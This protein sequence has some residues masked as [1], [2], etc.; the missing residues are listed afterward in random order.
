MTWWALSQP[1]AFWLFHENGVKTSFVDLD[2]AGQYGSWS[3][4][5]T[6]C[7]IAERG[8]GVPW[9]SL[10]LCLDVAQTPESMFYC[11]TYP[12][13]TRVKPSLLLLFVNIMAPSK[14]PRQHRRMVKM[15]HVNKWDFCNS[16]SKATKIG[17][18]ILP[19]V[20]SEGRVPFYRGQFPVSWQHMTAYDMGKW[21][22][23]SSRS[24]Y[25]EQG[26]P[27]PSIPFSCKRLPWFPHPVWHREDHSNSIIPSERYS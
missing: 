22:F 15:F 8:T 9:R 11:T 1:T 6:S 3:D 2:A 24:Y 23:L 25:W 26:H 14:S 20:V 16:S 27:G 13:H 12:D 19:A 5:N 21:F 17:I 18:Q 10:L 7:A 4:N